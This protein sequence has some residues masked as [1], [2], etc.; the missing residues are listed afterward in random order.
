MALVI[1]MAGS[2][3]CALAS[4]GSLTPSL[5]AWDS[6]V[7]ARP[8]PRTSE[9]RFPSP[10][11]ARV[12][13]PRATP[14]VFS[15]SLPAV[16]MMALSTKPKPTKGIPLARATLA[17]CP[18]V[19]ATGLASAAEVLRACSR[20]ATAQYLSNSALESLPSMSASA[21]R[22]AFSRPSRPSALFCLLRALTTA[23]LSIGVRHSASCVAVPTGFL[24]SL[25]TST[26]V[27]SFKDGLLRKGVA[28]GRRYEPPSSPWS[29]WSR[30][31]GSSGGAVVVAVVVVPARRRGRSRREGDDLRAR[32]TPPVRAAILP[33]ARS[34]TGT[35]TPHADATTT[36]KEPNG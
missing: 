15:I 29:L 20:L 23:P 24:L 8:R 32:R 22:N 18:L 11:A 10:A 16:S 9:I 26:P 17:S 4:L 28:A 31:R 19:G 12:V 21:S 6:I 34:A 36:T 1:R 13:I 2:L 25:S 35:A 14:R 3:S 7:S 30:W 33:S 5:L 27:T